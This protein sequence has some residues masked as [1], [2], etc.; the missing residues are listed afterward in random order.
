MYHRMPRSD[1]APG[2]IKHQWTKCTI[3][4][5]NKKLNES[6]ICK[7][8]T[9]YRRPT[10]KMIMIEGN[11]PSPFGLITPDALSPVCLHYYSSLAMKGLTRPLTHPR[12]G[13]KHPPGNYAVFLSH[14]KPC[15]A[16]QYNCRQVGSAGIEKRIKPPTQTAQRLM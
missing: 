9:V 5:C 2:T 14:V 4:N 15:S 6:C 12:P 13:L 7:N 1:N 16:L 11:V 3:N 8:T 10:E